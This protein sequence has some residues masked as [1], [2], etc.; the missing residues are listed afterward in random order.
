MEACPWIEFVMYGEP[1]APIGTPNFRVLEV[2]DRGPETVFR[3][4]R[5]A[6]RTA[7]QPS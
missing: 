4:P 6:D 3:A 2:E 7:D 5:A 1:L